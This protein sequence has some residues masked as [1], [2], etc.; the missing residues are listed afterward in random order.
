[1]FVK[2]HLWHF[3][4]L[5]VYRW[6]IWQYSFYALKKNVNF[7]D[8]FL[9][10]GLQ[11]LPQIKKE[12]KWIPSG[13]FLRPH[14]LF[15]ERAAPAKWIWSPPP[16]KEIR[17]PWYRHRPIHRVVGCICKTASENYFA[18]RTSERPPVFYSM[19]AAQIVVS[20]LN[21]WYQDFIFLLSLRMAAGS[22]RIHWCSP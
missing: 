6:H 12:A 19:G 8:F 14:W 1:V 15:V 10:N 9:K 7:L 18:I 16:K 17:L 2:H 21:D 4:K 22:T 11:I 20:M 3:L 13:F 5:Y